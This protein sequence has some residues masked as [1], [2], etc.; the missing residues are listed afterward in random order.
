MIKI[1]WCQWLLTFV[2]F[3]CKVGKELPVGA[4]SLKVR[5]SQIF[6]LNF[7][8]ESE[9]ALKNKLNASLS[10]EIKISWRLFMLSHDENRA[11]RH[12]YD[13]N[14]G[15]NI[16]SCRNPNRDAFVPVEWP[17]YYSASRRHITLKGRMNSNSIEYSQREKQVDFIN[18]VVSL[19]ISEPKPCMAYSPE[20]IIQ[21]SKKF[22]SITW[23]ICWY[24]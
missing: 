16:V 2:F 15:F 18:S 1:L 23:T 13:S 12:C 5:F 22:T 7:I 10:C 24:T 21:E 3:S 20:K 17:E 4:V 6:T 11:H 19:L 9:N 8:I 14:E